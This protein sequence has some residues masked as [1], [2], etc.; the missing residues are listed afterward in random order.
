MASL[1]L[2]SSPK[3]RKVVVMFEWMTRPQKEAAEADPGLVETKA[4]LEASLGV[5]EV[6]LVEDSEGDSGYW[7]WRQRLGSVERV[8]VVAQTLTDGGTLGDRTEDHDCSSCC[9]PNLRRLDRPLHPQCQCR[10]SSRSHRHRAWSTTVDD[11]SGGS[12]AKRPNQ[13]FLCV[14]SAVAAADGHPRWP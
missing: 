8:V 4:E 12:R 13:H 5:L 10:Y 9:Q 14:R 7:P 3:K 1:E 2:P 11:G 6:G